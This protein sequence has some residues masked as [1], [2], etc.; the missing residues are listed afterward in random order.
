ME[1][2]PYTT[3]WSSFMGLLQDTFRPQPDPHLPEFDLE[4]LEK[5]LEE[6][7]EED[8]DEDLE[9]NPMKNIKEDPNGDSVEV[10]VEET[11]VEEQ[12]TLRGTRPLVIST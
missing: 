2:D 7:P 4:D 5:D 6:D 3:S 12:R 10:E 9:E 1:V 11:I 8:P